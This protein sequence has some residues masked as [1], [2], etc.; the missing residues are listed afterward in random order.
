M[1]AIITEQQARLIAEA[2][3]ADAMAPA[4][5][6]FVA[7]KEE[8]ATNPFINTGYF[9]HGVL[10]KMA[11]MRQKEVR[12][13]FSDDIDSY[14]K[15]KV[16]SKLAKLVTKTVKSEEPIREQ[17]EKICYNTVIQI[18]GI[19]KN[20][21]K[22]ECELLPAISSTKSFHVEPDTDEEFEYDTVGDIDKYDGDT[23]KRRIINALSYGAAKAI[24]EQSRKLWVN[25]VLELDE[26][27]P[28][29]YTQIMKINDYLVFNTDI[30]ITDK[31]H[32]QG[33][34]VEMELSSEDEISTIK[35]YGVVFPILLQETIRGI[36]DIIGT[37]G[38]PDDKQSAQRVTNI[39][40]ALENDPWNMRFGPAM[41]NKIASC[42]GDIDT[43]AF[44]EFFKKLVELDT[45]TFAATMKEVFAGTR[46]GKEQIKS[47][48]DE[49][50]Y[51]SE[52]KRFTNDLALKRGRDMISDDC[53]TEEELEGFI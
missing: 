12:E 16:F 28:Y 7:E 17:L 53:F 18:F 37:F 35:A 1:K 20:A 44:P 24:A 46:R 51:D 27:L 41:W 15:D 2:Q 25:D 47:I 9:V 14:P 49:V 32:K 38:L 50:K 40:D 48:Y 4:L 19:E 21:V 42:I 33:G 13:Y 45:E 22:L 30:K 10:N 29:L 26:E 3:I 11:S 52:Y 8:K 5:P 6:D 36:I 31:S 39:A 23:N 43:E 34:N